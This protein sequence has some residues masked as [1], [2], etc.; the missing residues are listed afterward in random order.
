M[1]P[2]RSC[3]FAVSCSRGL[4]VRRCCSPTTGRRSFGPPNLCRLVGGRPQLGVMSTSVTDVN[5][6]VAV[7]LAALKMP[8]P[9]ASTVLGAAMQEFVDQVRPNDPNDWLTLV[10]GASAASRQRI[11]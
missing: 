10:R 3:H 8:A 7:M 6:H 1:S 4:E 2:L 9:L 5:L 11:E